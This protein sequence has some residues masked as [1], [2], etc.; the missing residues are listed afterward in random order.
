[1]AQ[2]TMVLFQSWIGLFVTLKGGKRHP[3]PILGAMASP[4]DRRLRP[5]TPGNPTTRGVHTL[6]VCRGLSRAL[7]VGEMLT[8][9]RNPSGRGLLVTALKSRSA[10][11]V[12]A[13]MG[14][15][16]FSPAQVW[17]QACGSSKLRPR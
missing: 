1:M 11:V 17:R 15:H 4:S 2:E 13:L 7:Q 10:P 8:S 3:P 14:Q 9:A 6:T 16:A 5:L 12:R